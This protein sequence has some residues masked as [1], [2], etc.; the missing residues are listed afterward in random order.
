MPTKLP[1]YLSVVVEREEG[2]KRSLFQVPGW[3]EE[4]R[5]GWR[6]LSEE[7]VDLWK[8]IAINELGRKNFKVQLTPR[9]GHHHL[10]PFAMV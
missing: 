3:F 9:L 1:C 8:I 2:K 4:G 6:V 5:V 7:S 10:P